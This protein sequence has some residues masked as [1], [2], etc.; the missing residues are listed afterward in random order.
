MINNASPLDTFVSKQ[1]LEE[2]KA[3]LRMF[4]Y[5]VVNRVRFRNNVNLLFGRFYC[6]PKY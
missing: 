5:L 3:Y 6:I 4:L 2:F 1:E